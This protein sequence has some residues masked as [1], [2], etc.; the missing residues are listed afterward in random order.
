MKTQMKCRKMRHFIRVCT[1]P[2]LAKINKSAQGPWVS[3]LI[4]KRERKRLVKDY[5]REQSLRGVYSR[6]QLLLGKMTAGSKLHR[7]GSVYRRVHMT[8]ILLMW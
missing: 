5:P 1:V 6:E 8:G 2:L 7:F 4:W 3:L